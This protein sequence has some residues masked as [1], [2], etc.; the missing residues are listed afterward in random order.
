MLNNMTE[1][2]TKVVLYHAFR[3]YQEMSVKVT[4]LIIVILKLCFCTLCK[5]YVIINLR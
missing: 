2:I 5:K 4:F 1:G 3:F